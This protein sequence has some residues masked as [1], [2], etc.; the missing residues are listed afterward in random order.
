[1][2]VAY[3]A[4]SSLVEGS[5]TTHTWAHT[6]TG[7]N[8]VL[9][10]QISHASIALVTVT[11]VTY[12]GVAMTSAGSPVNN[13]GNNRGLSTFYLIGPDTGTN[14][15]VVSTN[16]SSGVN[17]GAISLTGGNAVNNYTTGTGG[18]SPSINV[19]SAVGNMVVDHV[20]C[21]PANG[22]A[23]TAGAGQTARYDIDSHRSGGSTEAGAATT[24]M[25][26]TIDSS[27]SVIA[28]VN[29]VAGAQAQ[30]YPVSAAE[31]LSNA[32]IERLSRVWTAPR[33][34]SDTVGL[35][36]EGTTRTVAYQRA[37]NE[38]FTITE[39]VTAFRGVIVSILESVQI[40][41]TFGRVWSAVRGLSEAIS[42]L[43]QYIKKYV[44]DLT[45]AVHVSDTYSRTV[46]F[47][48][49]VLS[50]VVA[51]TDHAS[52]P[53]NWINRTKPTA[54]WRPRQRP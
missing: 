44:L 12:N 28:A 37:Q 36:S 15:I 35:Q 39:A 29:V 48:S 16:V 3:D 23:L 49:R 41:E 4:A 42:I 47:L 34:N 11:G 40:T 53:L 19:T 14:N 52:F 1:M 18:G 6:C 38:T 26:W 46:N 9:I 45:E 31:D 7:S 13:A 21:Q 22:G 32:I 27:A 54:I 50:E 33:S 8:R 2:A 17:C 24:T 20:T 51:I 43:D 30:T 25:S 5:G 10:V